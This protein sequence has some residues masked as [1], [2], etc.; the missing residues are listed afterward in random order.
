MI[1]AELLKNSTLIGARETLFSR[2][3][4]RTSVLRK[5]VSIV[6]LFVLDS[7]PVSALRN[8]GFGFRVEF[9]NRVVKTLLT[10]AVQILRHMEALRSVAG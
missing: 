9:I 1:Q 6:T 4:R 5:Q 3:G 8:A 10:V 7:D 2:A